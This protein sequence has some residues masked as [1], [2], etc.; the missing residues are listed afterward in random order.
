MVGDGSIRRHQW[1]ELIM[2]L[3]P[4]LDAYY[5]IMFIL[6]IKNLKCL[7]IVIFIIEICSVNTGNITLHVMINVFATKYSGL[8]ALS[9]HPQ[10]ISFQMMSF[11]EIRKHLNKIWLFDAVKTHLGK[12]SKRFSHYWQSGKGFFVYPGWM[13]KAQ[14][15]IY[16]VWCE[17]WIIILGDLQLKPGINSH[18]LAYRNGICKCWLYVFIC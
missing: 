2:L 6:L 12:G 14:V 16:R 1:E 15:L 10:N 7:S 4:L 8:L 11:I 9:S 18:T 13:D 5:A 3:L 17:Q